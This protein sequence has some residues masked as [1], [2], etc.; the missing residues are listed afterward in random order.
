MKNGT[1]NG[2]NIDDKNLDAADL[3]LTDGGRGRAVGH[4]RW[5]GHFYRG[6][7]APTYVGA[8]DYATIYPQPPVTPM[9]M[10]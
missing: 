8:V 9:V 6:F 1:R 10:C 7:A 4:H 5:G 3:Q 2:K